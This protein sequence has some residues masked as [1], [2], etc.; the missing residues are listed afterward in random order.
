MTRCRSLALASRSHSCRYMPATVRSTG[1]PAT[2]TPPLR[3]FSLER[4]FDAADSVLNLSCRLVCLAVGLQLGIAKHLA[5]DL[6]DFAFDLMRRS[7][8]PIFVHDV[9][10]KKVG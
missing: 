10:S 7:L 2:R 3:L 6:F 1:Y 9:F 8:D 4:V 5:G